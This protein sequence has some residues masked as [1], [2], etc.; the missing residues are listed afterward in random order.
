MRF[1]PCWGLE[2]ALVCS[3]IKHYGIATA[4][5][6]YSN[7]KFYMKDIH[8]FLPDLK[9]WNKR[10][11]KLYLMHS[12][13]FITLHY[14]NKCKLEL[15]NFRMSCKDICSTLAV[16]CVKISSMPEMVEKETKQRDKW[17]AVFEANSASTDNR[18]GIFVLFLQYQ[19]KECPFSRHI[20][21]KLDLDAIW[22]FLSWQMPLRCF[23]PLNRSIIFANKALYGTAM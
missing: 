23:A 5:S 7:D 14:W 13:E 11:M 21:S 1:I 8:S 4:R 17:N 9:S 19:E 16:F 18:S 6:L 3:N 10:F 20:Q 12:L 2:L 15:H 22:A